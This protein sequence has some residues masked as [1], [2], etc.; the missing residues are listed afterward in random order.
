GFIGESVTRPVTFDN[1]GP[2]VAGR[3]IGV[4]A[5]DAQP[6]NARLFFR[7][8]DVD[9]IEADA[10]LAGVVHTSRRVGG[11]RRVELE[12]GGAGHLVEVDLPFDHP[13]GEKTRLAFRPRRWKLFPAA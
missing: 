9:L 13:A 4:P 3:A 11:T 7:P 6:G 1:A 12:I 10:S 2:W 5:G 8:H